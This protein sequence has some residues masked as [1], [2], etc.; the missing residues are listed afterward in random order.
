[1]AGKT[2]TF[3]E[4]FAGIGGFRL[5][6]EKVNYGLE[7]V[8]SRELLQSKTSKDIQGDSTN[9]ESRQVG[10]TCVYAN[11]L[12]KYAAQIY[13]RHYEKPDTR[14]IREVPATDIP[15]HDLLTA[16]FPCQ[17]F[18]IAGKRGGFND[19]R[20][21][22]FFEVARILKA[23]RPKYLLLENVKGLLSSKTPLPLDSFMLIYSEEVALEETIR[24]TNFVPINSWKIL[25]ENLGNYLN[26]IGGLDGLIGRL[27]YLQTRQ[28]LTMK[29]PSTLT[30]E[31]MRLYE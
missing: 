30:T 7:A 14:D 18:S 15:D 21:T 17:S 22:L 1:M 16:G 31:L 20:G 10:F 25:T 26:K 23:K 4:L 3:C 13:E 8:H 6:L 27:R 11:E 29:K 24:C 19:T 5:G 12:N 28:E 9:L 2:I